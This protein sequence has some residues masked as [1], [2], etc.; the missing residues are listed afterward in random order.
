MVFVAQ[1]DSIEHISASNPFGFDHPQRKGQRWMF[2]DVGMIYVFFCFNCAKKASVLQYHQ[3]QWVNHSSRPPEEVRMLSDLEKELVD[4][5]RKIARRPGMY[6]G[7][8]SFSRLDGFICGFLYA[9]LAPDKPDPPL[10]NK[11]SHWQ[12]EHTGIQKEASW[13]QFIR[14]Y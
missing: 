6:L 3:P 14:F 4:V 11:F 2:S 5:L 1:I 12:R 10:L 9:R 8:A 7:S 13:S